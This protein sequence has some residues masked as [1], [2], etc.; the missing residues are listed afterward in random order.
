MAGVIIPKRCQPRSYNTLPDSTQTGRP[1]PGLEGEN[2]QEGMKIFP[3]NSPVLPGQP[4]SRLTRLVRGGVR[5]DLSS[6]L[7]W[8]GGYA[9]R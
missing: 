8:A 3:N 9:Q 6:H 7:R 4:A 1:R 2:Q 5:S